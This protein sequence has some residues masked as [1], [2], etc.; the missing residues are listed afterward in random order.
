MEV[1]QDYRE[2]LGLLNKHEVEYIIVGSYALAY[3]GAPRSTGDLDI[4]VRTSTENADRITKTLEAFGFESPDLTAADFLEPERV[5]QIGVP[6]VRVDLMTSLTGISWDEAFA[7][8]VRGE[9][10]DVPVFYLGR[11]QFIANKQALG[12]KKD[13]ADLEVLGEG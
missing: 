13:L 10:G 4:L 7:G 9:Y 6:P 1:Q 12:R 8:R 3:H 5:V 11:D 2:L